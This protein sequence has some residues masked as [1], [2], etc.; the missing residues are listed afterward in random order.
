MNLEDRKIA[1]F[2]DDDQDFLTV[3]LHTIRHPLF[4]IQVYCATNGYQAIDEIIKAKPDVVF[5]DFNLPRANGSQVI[6]VLKSINEFRDLPVYFITGYPRDAVA[7]FLTHLEFDGLLHKDDH[8]A[9]G[10]LQI[11]DQLAGTACQD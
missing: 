3:L 2:I 5:I 10:I 11:L 6:P 8:F 7:S 4:D 9:E 1:F